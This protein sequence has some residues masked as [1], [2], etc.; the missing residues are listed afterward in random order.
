MSIPSGQEQRKK[1]FGN[2]AVGVLVL[3]GIFSVA[4]VLA[5]RESAAPTHKEAEVAKNM[6]LPTT[7]P[8]LNKEGYQNALD[9]PTLRT[10][11]KSLRA[12]RAF[13]FDGAVLSYEDL[14][15]SDSD[16]FFRQIRFEN[17]DV[18]ERYSGQEIQ[19]AATSQKAEDNRIWIDMRMPLESTSRFK[20]YGISTINL[21]DTDA[22]TI[23]DYTQNY[24][25][26]GGVGVSIKIAEHAEL[27]FDF[28]HTQTLRSASG[29]N[30]PNTSSTGV[31]LKL[32]F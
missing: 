16:N 12:S 24:G 27:N 9:K 4:V 22:K 6:E 10:R 20:L 8:V 26:G 2:I 31:S 7:R 5:N 13:R 19:S 25:I 14:S 18:V 3:C 17:G 21:G 32:E 11:R 15:E 1:L 30:D 29:E 23:E 28:R